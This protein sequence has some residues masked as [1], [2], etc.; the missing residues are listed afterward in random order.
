MMR[1]ARNIG[2]LTP[3]VCTLRIDGIGYGI[4]LYATDP[5][6]IEADHPNVTVDGRLIAEVWT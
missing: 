4:T 5:E 1:E 6:Q 2:P 3:W